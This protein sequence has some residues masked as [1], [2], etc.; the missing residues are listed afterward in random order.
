VV[1]DADSRAAARVLD[2]VA[3]TAG[4]T[5]Y[6]G[7]RA[8]PLSSP[9]GESLLAHELAHVMQ[10]RAAAEVRVDAVSGP[11]D[12]HERVANSASQNAV[13]GESGSPTTVGSVPAVQR[14]PDD[15]SAT[16]RAG[17]SRAQAQQVLEQ[18]FQRT[19]EA[20]GGTSVRMTADVKNTI[21]RIFLNDV[22]GVLR[23]DGFLSRTVFP[24]SPTELAAAVAPYLPDPIDPSR[25]AHL[26]IPAATPSKTERVADVVKKTAPSEPPPEMQEQKWRFDQN[27]KDLRRDEGTIGPYSVDLLRLYNVGKQLPDALKTPAAPKA[28]GKTY[29]EVEAAIAKISTTELIPAAVKGTAKGNEFADAQVMARDLARQ[30]DEA[31]QRRAE[32]VALRLG[33]NYDTVKD[34]AEIIQAIVR[35]VM[36]IRDALPHHAAAV[37]SV[38]L[39]FGEKVVRR[40][41]LGGS[42]E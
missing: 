16:K 5:I 24:G 12:A 10:Q 2:A 27:A 41:P 29:P 8:P 6:L 9:A 3:F 39:Y 4:S 32:S 28:E 23:I 19:L 26:G 18:Y 30:L 13:R 36:L 20:Q 33:A 14:Q 25:L 15:M 38:D 35:I 40:I 11:D 31:Q 37:R 34:R 17:L 1:D 22:G 42:V 21:R 7:E